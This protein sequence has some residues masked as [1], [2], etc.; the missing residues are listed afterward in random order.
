MHLSKYESK[1]YYKNKLKKLYNETSGYPNPVYMK[2]GRIIRIWKG[3]HRHNRYWF[4]KRC[5]NRYVRRT[6]MYLHG[7]QFKKLYDFWWNVD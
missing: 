3:T 5:A 1:L 6:D 4:Y 2:D 7:G